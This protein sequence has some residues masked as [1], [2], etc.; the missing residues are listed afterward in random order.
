MKHA[1]RKCRKFHMG[2][3]PYFPGL[4]DKARKLIFWRLMFRKKQGAKINTKYLRRWAKKID[5]QGSI[6]ISNYTLDTIKKNLGKAYSN[7][8]KIKKQAWECRRSFLMELQEKYEGEEK[9]RIK[10]IRKREENKNQWRIWKFVSSDLRSTA[11]LAV[12]TIKEVQKIRISERVELERAIMECLSKRFSL[13][14]NSFSIS[15]TF[16]SSV[17]YLAERK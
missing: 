16:T 10:D 5:F 8:Q 17:G 14:T 12:E 11:V 15:S 2:E 4:A 3:V 13:T 1:E 6:A 7:Y 9:A